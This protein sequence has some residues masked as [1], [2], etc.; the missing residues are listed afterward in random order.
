M[1]SRQPQSSQQQRS[2]HANTAMVNMQTLRKDANK[3]LAKINSTTQ[4]W[5]QKGKDWAPTEKQEEKLRN[6][7]AQAFSLSEHEMQMVDSADAAGPPPRTPRARPTPRTPAS[8]L[9]A[10]TAQWCS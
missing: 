9:K 8:A 5:R 10:W 3:A 7:Y 6:L 2:E 4:K 1:A